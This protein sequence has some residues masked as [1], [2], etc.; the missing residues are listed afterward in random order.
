LFPGR[1]ASGTGAGEA[2]LARLRHI[3]AN[4]EKDK[5][6]LARERQPALARSDTHKVGHAGGA[7]SDEDTIKEV[8]KE[9][10][11]KFKP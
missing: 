10:D 4:Y 8:S 5:A 3:E 2:E 1:G 6:M 7:A 9:L 11:R